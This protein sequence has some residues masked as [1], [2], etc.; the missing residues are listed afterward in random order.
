[1][2]LPNSLTG[3]PENAEVHSDGSTRRKWIVLNLIPGGVLWFGFCTDVSWRGDIPDFLY[4]PAVAF[5]ALIS[6]MRSDKGPDFRA[7]LLY[8]LACMPALIGGGIAVIAAVASI[9][10][11]LAAMFRF[12]E[13]ASDKV[14]Q[15]AV[16]PD[17]SRVADVHFRGVGAYAGGNGRVYVRVRYR[18]LP[19][20]E[21][22][23]VCVPRSYAD[24]NAGN[25]LEWKDADTLSFSGDSVPT[26][27]VGFI[28]FL[29]VRF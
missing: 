7:R 8:R 26:T 25:Y 12:S 11:P 17:G 3:A 29:G 9:A 4:P 19:F 2:V 10:N 18:W 5:V 22:D 24:E 1:M 23:V 21:R 15:S 20:V 28:R 27:T 14:I 13:F 16:S 6:L